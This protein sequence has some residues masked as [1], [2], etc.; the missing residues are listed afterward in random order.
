MLRDLDAV[1][2]LN[3][4]FVRESLHIVFAC[5]LRGYFHILFSGFGEFCGFD[6]RYIFCAVP[7]LIFRRIIAC[8]VRPDFQT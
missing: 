4:E 8:A 1:V 7:L 5:Q 6:F 3:F 2:N